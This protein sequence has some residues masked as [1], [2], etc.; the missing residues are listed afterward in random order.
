MRGEAPGVVDVAGV[1]E[2]GALLPDGGGHIRVV[3]FERGDNDAGGHV[4]VLTAVEVVELATAA[5][6]DDSTGGVM[7][8]LGLD[9]PPPT[10]SA[11]YICH[12]VP[13]ISHLSRCGGGSPGASGEAR[14]KVRAHHVST[15]QHLLGKKR[16]RAPN[17]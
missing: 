14:A 10:S 13:S 9:P 1:D 16:R 15:I 6:L 11:A 3:V 12:C 2:G 7:G 5:D 17:C 8:N 4:E